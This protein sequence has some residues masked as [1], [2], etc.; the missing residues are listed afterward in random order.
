MPDGLEMRMISKHFF[1]LNA[2]GIRNYIFDIR[3]A[4]R[5]IK[6]GRLPLTALSLNPNSVD[7]KILVYEDRVLEW[8]L[9]I[10]NR[11]KGDNEA[12]FVILMISLAY[13][14]G[15]QQYREGRSSH[16]QSSAFFKKG[17]KRVFPYLRRIA[18]VDDLLDN[19]YADVRCGLFHDSITRKK[20]T[21]SGQFNDPITLGKVIN[22][23]PHRFLDA[24]KLDFRKY[25]S[26]LKNKRNRNVREKFE[27]R[28]NISG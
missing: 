14:E 6:A 15:N 10:G 7:T 24:V 22:I 13:I 16:R 17:I 25:I 2:Q 8:F 11:L 19:F 1:Q 3:N 4:G 20:V 23:N 27:T 5:Y 9:N 26:I 21:I 18:N 28:W 12:G